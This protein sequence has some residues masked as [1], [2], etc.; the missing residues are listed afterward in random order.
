MGNGSYTGK[1]IKTIVIVIVLKT[2]VDSMVK[3]S[4]D[5]YKKREAK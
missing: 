1:I 2:I 5:E 3:T 4:V